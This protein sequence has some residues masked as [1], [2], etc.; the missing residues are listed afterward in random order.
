MADSPEP[1]L[2]GIRTVSEL[3]G[4]SI[5]TLRWYEREGLLP[6]VQRDPGGRRRYPPAAVRF[7]RLVQALRRTGMSVDDVR[8]FVRMGHGLEWHGKRTAL[9]E[10]HAASIERQIGRLYEDLAVVR[11][12]IAH[13]RD[14]ERRGLGCEDEIGAGDAADGGAR[15]A[16]SG[17][18][19]G[20]GNGTGTPQGG[21]RPRTTEDGNDHA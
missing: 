21:A 6:L 9:L 20:A 4:L 7:I 16:D 12:K 3:T 13:H 2:V 18:G 14:L 19:N 15:A 11:D 17:A 1:D 5:D 10:Q 8:S